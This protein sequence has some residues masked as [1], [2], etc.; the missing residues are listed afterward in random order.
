[1]ATICV[2]ISSLRCSKSHTLRTLLLSYIVYQILFPIIGKIIKRRFDT[3]AKDPRLAQEELLRSTIKRDAKTAYGLQHGFKEIKSMDDLR[4]MHPLT[5]YQHYEEYMERMAEG[6]ENVLLNEQLLRFGITSGTTGKGKLVPI[7]TTRFKYTIPML[8]IL[9]TEACKKKYGVPSP[10]QKQIILYVN[11]CPTTTPGGDVI[12]PMHLYTDNMRMIVEMTGNVPWE[13]YS[14]STE[15]EAHYITLLFG[16][17]DRDIGLWVGPL[18]SQI[19]KVMLKLEKLWEQLVHDIRTGTIDK[20]LKISQE[21]RSACE[22]ALS[23]EPERAE[24]LSREFEKGFNGIMRRIW[25][26]LKYIVGINTADFTNKL[27]EK[28]AKGN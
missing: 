7:L 6:E 25:L 20:N 8:Q 5:F 3:H 10:L 21:V 24:E 2:H 22:K 18:S 27:K 26:H 9:R 12:G 14:I 23:P 1:M 19:H 4:K 15:R 17:R 16:L 28:Y 11:P 13:A